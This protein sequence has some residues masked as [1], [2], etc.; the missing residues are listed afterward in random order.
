MAKKR[1]PV[2]TRTQTVI[3]PKSFGVAKARRWL[4]RHGLKS[5]KV[6]RTATELRFRQAPPGKC[7]RDS[8]ASI[9]M[10]STGVRKIICC[11]RKA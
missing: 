11:P 7:R 6:D 3:F 10:G 9:P 2:S 8:F 4:K 1:C 5:P